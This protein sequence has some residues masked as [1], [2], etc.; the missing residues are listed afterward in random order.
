MTDE[1]TPLIIGEPLP[2]PNSR[3]RDV[4][5]Q[6]TLTAI[7]AQQSAEES[8]KS[9]QEQNQVLVKKQQELHNLVCLL[10]LTEQR[11]RAHLAGELHDYLAQM[12]A[13]GRMKIG[14]ARPHLT[15]D[16]PI[17][18][19]LIQ[20]IDDIFAR[21]LVY[22]RT[23]MAELSPPVLQELGLPIALKWLA[24]QMSKHNLT[25][26]V[27]L[28]QE[29][30]SITEEKEVLLFQSVRELLINI[31]KHAKVARAIVSLMVDEQNCLRLVVQDA[32]LG[33]DPAS[34]ESKPA[35]EHFGLASIRE[36]MHT[37]DGWLEMQSAPGRG[38]TIILGLPL[39]QPIESEHAYTPSTIRRSGV[40]R[41]KK[42]T[43]LHRVLLVDDHT[44][45]RQGLRTILE[46]YPE[47]RVIGEAGNG[48]EA[49][50]MA[51]ELMPD[52]ILMDVNMPEMDGIQATKQIKATQAKAI[53]LG[54][55]MNDSTQIM[56]AMMEAGA[57]AFLS[58]EATA[59]ELH[60]AIVAG[61]PCKDGQ[62][63]TVS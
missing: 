24:E 53:I 44:M 47:M 38:T 55:S 16:Q 48:L 20:D 17:L 9:Y 5:E 28:S 14:I 45:V 61:A 43:A 13:L 35:G 23:L 22:T 54:L 39:N 37:M 15:A 50:A 51:A 30:V 49:V 25:V 11:E 40:T 4:N 52:V 41:V 8:S 3:L 1:Y 2:M 58:K 26:D 57:V 7:K 36:R 27:Y 12:L 34:L 18:T 46:S 21:S 59:D 63:G 62:I 32:G 33:F 31:V 6:L 10:T 42:G 60:E 56:Q 29:T 19:K